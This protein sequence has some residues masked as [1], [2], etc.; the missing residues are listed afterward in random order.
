[1]DHIFTA[2]DN[3]VATR[4]ATSADAFG[5]LQEP[6]TH[7]ETEIGG[8]ERADRTNIDR[9]KRI[10]IF[11]PL[12]GIRGQHRITTAIHKPEYIIVR[13]LLTKT[14]AARTENPALIIE[15]NARPEDNVFRFPDSVFAE[16]RSARAAVA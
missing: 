14:N 11:Q 7:L 5:F 8:S 10:T 16:T 12:A 15:P 13:Y 1:M 9:V 3:R 6:D 2:A 4:R